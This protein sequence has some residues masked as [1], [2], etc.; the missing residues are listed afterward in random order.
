MNVWLYGMSKHDYNPS[1]WICY[2]L[3]DVSVCGSLQ[4][5]VIQVMGTG[6]LYCIHYTSR[7]N[8][9]QKPPLK[10]KMV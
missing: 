7:L 1:I 2:V 8:S 5:L 9:K 3:D 10:T 6:N 4:E